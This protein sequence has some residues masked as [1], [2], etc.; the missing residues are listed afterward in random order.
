[1]P[2]AQR[3]PIGHKECQAALTTAAS[4]DLCYLKEST[5]PVLTA[6]SQ[7]ELHS[8]CPSPSGC[9]HCPTYSA[10]LVIQSCSH[11]TCLGCCAGDSNWGLPESLPKGRAKTLLWDAHL[12]GGNAE[13]EPMC[14]ELA[15]TFSILSPSLPQTADTQ[16][17]GPG[18]RLL[19][20]STARSFCMATASASLPFCRPSA[21]FKLTALP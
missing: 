17:L 5:V 14:F 2:S 6:L 12:P 9:P 10:I 1:M 19:A 7:R 16:A 15:C 3:N 8:R 4:Q 11:W 13:F 21:H 20:A 18:K